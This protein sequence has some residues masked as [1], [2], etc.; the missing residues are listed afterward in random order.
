VLRLFL[1]PKAKPGV[2]VAAHDLFVPSVQIAGAGV[3]GSPTAG[4]RLMLILLY[5]KHPNNMSDEHFL[6]HWAENVVWQYFSGMT[7]YEARLP[8]NSTQM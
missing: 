6:E 8:C 3:C 1:T 5:L 4:T 2:R 7:H